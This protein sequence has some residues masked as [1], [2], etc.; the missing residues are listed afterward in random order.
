MS[1]ELKDFVNS[2]VKKPT[3]NCTIEDLMAI[4][5][6]ITFED[7]LKEHNHEIWRTCECGNE[8][9]LRKTWDCS[10]CGKVI[11]KPK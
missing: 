2:F 1:P 10:K 9:D 8:E 11:F 7:L 6:K 3:I 4:P 5:K